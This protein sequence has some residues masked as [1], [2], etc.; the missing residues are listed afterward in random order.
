[1]PLVLIWSEAQP[2]PDRVEHQSQNLAVGLIRRLLDAGLQAPEEF[3]DLLVTQLDAPPRQDRPQRIDD[4]RFPVDQG[5]VAVEGQ[6]PVGR[7]IQRH[8]KTPLASC[9]LQSP[10]RGGPEDSATIPP[11]QRRNGH[12]QLEGGAMGS[13]DQ[14]NW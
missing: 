10:A 3:E 13:P 4:A 9:P 2:L 8:V 5:P 7:Q 12:S 1:R 14:A 11:P 6:D